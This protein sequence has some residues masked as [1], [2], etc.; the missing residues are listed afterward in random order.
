[1]WKFYDSRIASGTVDN[2]DC[3]RCMAICSGESIMNGLTFSLFGRIIF[4]HNGC[5]SK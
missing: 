1:M 4:L 5:I 3:G 2:S